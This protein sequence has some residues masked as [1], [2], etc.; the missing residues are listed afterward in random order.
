MKNDKRRLL[1]DL[2]FSNLKKG[3]V[4]YRAS[5]G[6]SGDFTVSNGNTYYDSGSG[7]SNGV[8]TFNELE[9]K[10]LNK[11]WDDT[12]WFKDA[13]LKHIDFIPKNSSITLRFDSI[14]LEEVEELTKGLIHIL[15]HLT[16]KGYV[17]NKFS[18]ITTSIK[19]N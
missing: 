2:P 17:W 3:D 13:E 9:E 7:S 18:D 19:N 16:D 12:E 1:K 5:R 15:P 8:K 6:Q 11:I 10:I 14:D 4:L